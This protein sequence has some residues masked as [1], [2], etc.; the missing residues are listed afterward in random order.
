[1]TRLEMIKKI[2]HNGLFLRYPFW[3]RENTKMTDE[4]LIELYEETEKKVREYALKSSHIYSHEPIKG[5][6]YYNELIQRELE[7]EINKKSWN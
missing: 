5:W 4:R 2:N 7:I 1:M 6:Q 3:V